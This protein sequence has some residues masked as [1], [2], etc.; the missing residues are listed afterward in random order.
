MKNVVI[1][2]AVRTPFGN[3]G[4]VLKDF[5][6]PE[7]GARAIRCALERAQVKPE[8]VEEI[9]LGIN[10][11]GADRSI[12]RQAALRA[13][14]PEE[15][16]AYSVD[17]A[18]CSSMVAVNLIARAIRVGDIQI[19]VAGGTENMSMVP[20]FLPQARW[21]NRLGDFTVKD[22]LVI[23]CP[24]TG[25]PR[26]VQAG[27]EALEYSI[28]REEQD[29]WALLSH[30]RY[31]AALEAGKFKEE[32]I[33]IS[34]PQP[35]GDPLVMAQDEPPRKDT[36]LEKLAKL[37][38]VYGSP[39][40]TPGNAPGLN[41]GASAIVMMEEE[42]SRRRN[43][44]PLAKYVAGALVSGHPQKLASIPAVAAKA[45]LKKAGVPLEK[46]DLI[47]INEAFAAMPLV[48]TYILGDGDPARVEEIRKRTNVNGG[49]IAIGHPTGATAARL[50][51]TLA[52]ELRRRG[53]GYGLATLCGGI[54]EGEAV[55]IEVRK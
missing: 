21:G 40:V 37:K 47:E 2:G 38:T 36:S 25:V 8:E 28:G 41:T 23:S 26:A 12:T 54:G 1:T 50:V 18:C 17:R 42:E 52:Y 34:I 6:L 55:I 24:H 22:Q 30:Q 33:P 53:G 5:T 32:V 3:F 19:G 46:I 15:K 31:F 44:K 35:K 45:A 39:T 51:M 4:G 27:E 14:I 48:S 11:P 7:L 13:G 43:L 10:L 20:Y 9:A 16:V 29:Q 49:A